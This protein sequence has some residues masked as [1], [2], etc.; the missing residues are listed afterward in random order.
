MTSFKKIRRLF[1]SAV[2]LG[3]C[4]LAVLANSASATE[5]PTV[6]TFKELDKGA[7]FH[8]VDNPPEA[9]L[10]QGVVSFSAGDTVITTNPLA[11]EGKV[12]GKIRIVC[13][14]T[15]TG[16]TKTS[17]RPALTARA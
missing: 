17:Q 4:V 3:S 16:S 5:G 6:L 12:V 15:A 7:T 9:T 10:E 8:F 14:A 1:A 11:M 13:T 2:V